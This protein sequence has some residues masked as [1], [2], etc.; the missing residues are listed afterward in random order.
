VH[1]GRAR[2]AQ[3]WRRTHRHAAQRQKALQAQQAQEHGDRDGNVGHELALALLGLLGGA[4]HLPVPRPVL[5]VAAAC[6]SARFAPLRHTKHG[7]KGRALRCCTSTKQQ[8]VGG[9]ASGG[10]R[11]KTN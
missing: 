1:N 4:L 11:S 3:H 9:L 6:Q 5:Y 8:G 7:Q 10:Q 2:R